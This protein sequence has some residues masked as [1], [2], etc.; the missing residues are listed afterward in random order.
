MFGKKVLVLFE[1]LLPFQSCFAF[2][3]G[4]TLNVCRQRYDAPSAWCVSPVC[5]S[6][7]HVCVGA[8]RTCRVRV[9]TSYFLGI[10]HSCRKRRSSYSFMDVCLATVGKRRGALGIA[11]QVLDLG[12]TCSLSGANMAR[13][14]SPK[15]RCNEER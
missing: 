12:S 9:Q 6:L 14:I 11:I 3:R 5:G 15:G 7:T 2:T 1:T 8:Q 10:T 13:Y 4:A